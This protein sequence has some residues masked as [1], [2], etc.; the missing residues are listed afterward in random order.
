MCHRGFIGQASGSIQ[1][2]SADPC[3]RTPITSEHRSGN[4][5]GSVRTGVVV[6]VSLTVVRVM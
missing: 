4:H 2:P 5:P 1:L 6:V 3:S